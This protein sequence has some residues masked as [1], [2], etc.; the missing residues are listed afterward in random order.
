MS[1]GE[2][3]SHRRRLLT[4]LTSDIKQEQHKQLDHEIHRQHQLN[5]ITSS[6]FDMSKPHVQMK[7]TP[8]DHA[9]KHFQHRLSAVDD[10][11]WCQYDERMHCVGREH[12]QPTFLVRLL[13]SA[14]LRGVA[15]APPTLD[16]NVDQW[17][18]A[19]QRFLQDTVDVCDGAPRVLSMRDLQ[20]CCCT[21]CC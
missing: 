20:V 16:P 15:I 1:D 7:I 3:V 11:S 9:G 13:P 17:S 18:K 19:M 14:T 5:S 10:L 21:S 2:D 6:A 8:G 4:K 12:P